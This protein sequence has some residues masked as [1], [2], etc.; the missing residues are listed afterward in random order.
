MT[1]YKWSQAAA[2]NA[3]ADSTCPF[4]EGMSPALVNDGT[5]G[6]MAAAAKYR[7]DVAGAIVSAGTSTAYTVASYQVFDTLAH[8]DGKVIAFTPHANNGATVTLNVDGLGAKPLRA[9]PG[10]E[11]QS[12]VLIQGTPYAAVYNNTDGAFYLFGVGPSP[13]IP[14]GSGCDFWGTIA[15]SSNF[16]FPS[17][18]EVS[19]TTYA[20]LFGLIGTT[21]GPGNGSTTFNLPDKR[22]RVSAA[23]DNMNGTAAGRL[24][25][26][27]AVDGTQLGY[28]AGEQLHLLTEGELPSLTKDVG[29]LNSGGS[30][31]SINTNEGNLLRDPNGSPQPINLSGATSIFL[32]SAR[33]TASITLPHSTVS[34]G[35][36]GSHNN[37]QPTIVCNYIMR[38]I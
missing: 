29:G 20:T 33:G 16:V 26:A 14:I 2:S 1:F 19:R 12:G 37:V 25:A 30:G 32:P 23:K 8:L 6:M 28:A 9:Q 22:G 31:I 11:L 3:T 38:I 13:G 15:P 34:F 24:T 7:D 35:G 17:G 5:R 36:G 10:V 27:G 21:Y 4:P 18:Q